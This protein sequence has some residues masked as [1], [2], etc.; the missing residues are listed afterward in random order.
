M[1]SSICTL[2]VEKTAVPITAMMLIVQWNLP[3]QRKKQHHVDK[4][5][6][7]PKLLPVAVCKTAALP[8]G[9]PDQP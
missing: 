8:K 4:T 9:L 2:A 3:L 7:L 6:P 1:C 5:M